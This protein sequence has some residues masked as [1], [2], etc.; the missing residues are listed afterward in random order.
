MLP[1]FFVTA[2]TL[3]FALWAL[4]QLP[5]QV[6]THWGVDGEPNGWSSPVFAALMMPGVMLLM[7]LL[8]AALPG[9]DPLKRN[10]EFHGSVYFLLAN[11]VVAF[12][13]AVQVAVLGSALGWPL[14]MRRVLPVLIGLLFVVMGNLIPRIR[15]NWFM[16]IRTPW[17]L[18]SERVWRKTHRVGGYTFILA[19][20]L[21]IATAFLA[22]GETGRTIMFVSIFPVILWPVIY[23]YLEWRREKAEGTPGVNPTAT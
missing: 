7:S 20:L 21:F 8:F 5:A 6:A 9:I 15:P 2:A 1:A 4:P 10:Y 3:G 22:T 11:V 14:E 19:G 13:G 16:G 18:S 17:T 12:I 23:S